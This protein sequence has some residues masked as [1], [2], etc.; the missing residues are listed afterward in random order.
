[1][2]NNQLIQGF[3]IDCVCMIGIYCTEYVYKLVYPVIDIR[4]SKYWQFNKENVLK[5]IMC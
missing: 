2:D 5:Y 1:M 3:R 4:G